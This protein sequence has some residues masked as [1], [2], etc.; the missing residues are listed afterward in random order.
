MRWLPIMFLSVALT[1]CT[2][3]KFNPITAGSRVLILGDSITA[4]YGFGP[5]QS[6]TTRL[7]SETGWHIINAGVSGDTSSSG[8][9]RLPGLIEEHSPVAVI[10]ELGGNDMLRRQSKVAISTNLETMI[11]LL[12]DQKILPILMSIPQPNIAG[13]VF[14]RLSDAP[15]YSEIATK[16]RIPLVEDAISDTLSKVE[17]KLDDIHPNVEGHQQIGRE[18]VKRLRKLGLL[19]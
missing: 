4:G 19:R 18:V 6:W 15:F 1:A 9:S 12:K 3:S 11:D 7:A 5:D 8:L 16:K 17:F 14:S 10:I 13:V 2:S